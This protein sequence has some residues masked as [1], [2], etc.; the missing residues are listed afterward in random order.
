MFGFGQPPA[1]DNCAGAIILTPSAQYFC[2]YT[3]IQGTTLN[4]TDSGLS[5]TCGADGDDDVWY[6]F[7]ATHETHYLYI[8]TASGTDPDIVIS[9]YTGICSSLDSLT[10]ANNNGFYSGEELTLSGLTIGDTIFLRIFDGSIG[11]SDLVFDICIYSPPSNDD[12]MAAIDVIPIS[13]EASCVNINTQASTN[14]GIPPGF[15]GGFPDDDVWYSFSAIQNFHNI[16][17]STGCEVFLPGEFILELMTG[18]CNS[19]TFIDCMNIPYDCQPYTISRNDFIIGET[20]YIRLFGSD[21]LTPS[22]GYLCIDTPPMETED[23]CSTAELLT[24]NGNTCNS[25]SFSNNIAGSTSTTTPVTSCNAGPY[26][27]L[28]YK[29]AATDTRHI[30]KIDVI[31]GGDIAADGF[32]G[33][34]SSLSFIDCVNNTS[35][36]EDEVLVLENLQ[37]GDS[38]YL[39]VFDANNLGESITF[40][41]CVLTPPVNDICSNATLI[42]TIDATA[43]N[44]PISGNTSAASGSGGCDGGIAD[45]DV[46][47]KFVATADTH[48]IKLNISTI[49]NPII[50]LF[51][52]CSGTSLSCSSDGILFI[53]NA[54]INNTYYFRVFSSGD[55]IGQGNFSVCVSTP[56][57]NAQCSLPITLETE[58]SC[59]GL[60]V[61]NNIG[62]PN[63]VYFTFEAEHSGYTIVISSDVENFSPS[64]SINQNCDIDNEISLYNNRFQLIDNEWRFTFG[65][66]VVGQIYNIGLNSYSQGDFTICILEPN[67]YDECADAEILTNQIEFIRTTHACTPS[68]S[69]PT[70][71]S[72]PNDYWIK[73][74]ANS[75]QPHF[76]NVQPYI[77]DQFISGEIL[78][79]SDC[80]NLSSVA[81][82]PQSGFGTFSAESGNTYYVRVWIKKN[83]PYLGIKNHTGDFIIHISDI[84]PSNNICANATII[85]HTTNCSYTP[86][87]TYGASKDNGHSSCS[88]DTNSSDVWYKF[89][90]TSSNIRIKVKTLSENFNPVIKLFQATSCSSLSFKVCA[91]NFSNGEDEVLQYNGTNGAIYYVLVSEGGFSNN[92]GNFE[93]CITSS[94]ETEFIL[95]KYSQ[96][97]SN[98][99]IGSF[100]N[101]TGEVKAYFVG[102]G[103]LNQIT[104]IKGQ[105]NTNHA[106]VSNVSSD[107]DPYPNGSISF[108]GSDNISGDPSFILNGT[109]NVTGPS[110]VFSNKINFNLDII[111]GATLGQ[112]TGIIVDSIKIGAISYPVKNTISGYKTI[113][114]FEDYYTVSDGNWNDQTSWT[115][116]IIPPALPS[117]NV[118]IRNNITLDDYHSA[119][120]LT[121]MSE[122]KLNIPPNTELTLGLS[123]L[124]SNTSHTSKLLSMAGKVI[125]TGGTLNVNGAM[126]VGDSLIMTSGVINID[127]NNGTSSSYSWHALSINT[128]KVKITGG[129]INI[130]DPSYFSA[131]NSINISGFS[132]NNV[133]INAVVKFGGGDDENSDNLR[134]FSIR[135]KTPDNNEFPPTFGLMHIDSLSIAGG[136]YSERRH[137]S[138]DL[139]LYVG[140]LHISNE[141]EVYITN[142]HTPLIITKNFINNGFCMINDDLSP[143]RSI[144][145]TT[146]INNSG[147]VSV[148]VGS[149]V[150]RTFGGTGLL[151][152]SIANGYPSGPEGNIIHSIGLNNTI[153]LQTPLTIFKLLDL[154]GG[155]IISS[156]ANLLTLGTNTPSINIA[157]CNKIGSQ[158]AGLVGPVKKWYNGNLPSYSLR[159][160]PFYNRACDINFSNTNLGYV[161]AEYKDETPLCAGLPI[162]NEQ[163]ITI[164]G[165]SPSGY[166]QMSG[167]NVSGNYSITLNAFLY[168]RMDGTYI[169][170]NLDKIR[171]IKKSPSNIWANSGATIT[172]GPSDMAI[173]TAT[174]LD[175]IADFGIGIGDDISKY[176]SINNGNWLIQDNWNQCSIPALETTLD[177]EISHNVSLSQ[178]VTIYSHLFV[179]NNGILNINNN[180][181]LQVGNPTLL[182]STNLESSSLLNVSNG[183]FKV[184]GLLNLHPTSNLEISPGSSL[185]VKQN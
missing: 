168:T 178:N 7:A 139:C 9:A 77:L 4:A 165:V 105:V 82:I 141:S 21:T 131:Y 22:Y 150:E 81:C 92:A 44:N 129:F 110:A 73:F 121:V 101:Y 87:T 86:G 17:F 1:N 147:F 135:S 113:V 24:V 159:V 31:A 88:T 30:V 158:F 102:S 15:C 42:S 95:A 83:I 106:F 173:V 123:S 36:G 148:A 93:I 41:I 145:F 54:V 175:G 149:S 3:F 98:V 49:I 108:F 37:I 103:S 96:T 2:D 65:E 68:S 25:S 35:M 70:C 115:C 107:F 172:T 166:W 133:N 84:E 157:S 152:N 143:Y 104:Q 46:W 10:C 59:T 5:T 146:T 164:R 55:D 16:T 51:D 114:G 177:V 94:T 138:P 58:A 126:S 116:G 14:S 56:P 18:A 127:P 72:S 32:I 140:S 20:Y 57:S 181:I 28:W 169:F 90:A 47:Y 40:D 179:K 34:C 134:G 154:H 136:M 64:V 62:T 160:I 48:A 132:N 79:G 85:N 71:E 183:L 13:G 23:E 156:D 97:Q 100:N 6:K 19:A 27:D 171:I 174:G 75:T 118:Y 43:C 162:T 142:N 60:G 53:N 39:R 26:Y 80:N 33:N 8:G 29:F 69:L 45:D 12:C 176:K 144:Y 180:S 89:T 67:L 38:V 74:I 130:L 184:F 66:F 185:E 99:S 76:V 155:K 170:D 111:C 122:G 11:V 119:G 91:N 120:N 124:G 50:E 117:S 182:K 109:A 161:L 125:I 151:S 167:N 128:T 153:R 78:V 61:Y 163:G 63:D 112:N 52:A 137:F